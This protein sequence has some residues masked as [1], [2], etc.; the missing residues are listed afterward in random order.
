MKKNLYLLTFSV[1]LFTACSK[2]DKPAPPPPT[3]TGSGVGAAVG[4]QLSATDSLSSFNGYYK[5]ATLSDQDVATGITVFAPANSTFGNGQ[6]LLN[7]GLPDSSQLKDYI[8]KG[9]LKAADLTDNKSLTTLSGKTLTVTVKGSDVRVNGV[10]INLASAYTGDGF[11]IYSASRLWNAAA[12]FSWTIWDATTSSVSKPTGDLA[13]GAAVALY[14]SQADYASGAKAVYS[15]TTGNDGLATFN[16][17][18]PGTYYVVASKG[19]INN[20]FNVYNETLNNAY[21]GYAASNVTDSAGNI[22]WKDL[23]ADG[24]INTSDMVAVPALTVQPN[25]DASLNGI[26]LIDYVTK[27]LQTANDAQTI[28]NNT[29]TGLL[30]AYSS[31]VTLDGMLSDDAGCSIKTSLCPYDNF[32]FTATD[33]NISTLWSGTYN[34]IGGLNRVI[35]DVPGMNVA[36]D[37]KTDLVAQAKGLRAYI[38]LIMGQY[39]GNLP[40]HN[41]ITSS[42]FP[43]ISRSTITQVYNTIITDLTAAVA[44]LPATRTN[45]NVQLTKPAAYGL[46]AKAALWQKDYAAVTGYTSQIINSSSYSLSTVN[47]WLTS[48]GN[49]ENIWSPS[50]SGIGLLISWYYAGVFPSTTVTV[51]PVLRYGQILLIDAEAQVALGN[52]S[53]AQQDLN[54]LLTRRAQSTVS[55][56]NAS[57]G[58]T[59]LASTWQTETYRQGDRFINLLRW[60][61]AAQ[62]LS[63]NGFVQGKS[64]LLPIPQSLWNGYPGLNQNSGY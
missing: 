44:D 15:I 26:I 53:T 4:K 42:L 10:S 11:I 35:K 49:A 61:M 5:T 50:F 36:A 31:M 47:T 30:L 57:D 27:P 16:G 22:K 9:L 2:K 41:D 20:V 55:F 6:V 54:A 19:Q 8:V 21:F 1:L 12:V 38:Y 18:R 34:L 40:I 48:A 46:L 39:F 33:A 29:Y 32:T 63:A 60:G 28:L 13:T 52:Y 17:V 25:K 43:G 7:G 23:N 14:N 3:P 59:A 58:M 37:Q 24:L 56:N 62:V 51:C 64:N 45:G